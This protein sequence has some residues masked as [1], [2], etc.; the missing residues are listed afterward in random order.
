MNIERYTPPKDLH[1]YFRE[2]YHCSF[3][4]EH[5]RLIPVVDDGCHDFIF[6]REQDSVWEYG[7]DKARIPIN[8]EVFTI[9]N[10]TPPYKILI[11]QTL[12]FFTIKVQPWLNSTFFPVG[13]NRG[14]IDLNSLWGGELITH[15]TE[16]FRARDNAHR[17]KMTDDF[18]RSILNTMEITHDDMVRSVCMDIYEVKGVITVQELE[19]KYNLSRQYLNKK[20]KNKVYYSIKDFIIIVRI[21]DLIKTRINNSHI[22]F[23]Q[24]A[25]DY[26]YFDQA[27]FNRDFK[28]VTGLTPGKFFTDLAPFLERHRR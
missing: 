5:A 7:P 1:P 9:H 17:F 23:T 14:I 18:L 25:L 12:E 6:F 4:A 13:N 15:H 16:V 20:F 2:Y 21:V 3:S 19:E 22:S 26:N 10:L 11:D 27:H 28:R 8:H 24:L